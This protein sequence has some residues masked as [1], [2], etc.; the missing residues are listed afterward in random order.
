[1]FNSRLQGNR[2][3]RRLIRTLAVLSFSCVITGHAQAQNSRSFPAPP[4][5][6]VDIGTHRLHILCKGEGQPAIIIDAGLGSAALEWSHLQTILSERSKTCIYDRAG[7]GWSEAGPLPRTSNRIASELKTLL[8]E[9]GI[10]APY[11]L[12]G[13]SF[14]GYNMQI[15]AS[16]N[17]YDVAGLLLVDSSHPEQVQR[18][19]ADPINLKTAPRHRTGIVRYSLPRLPENLPVGLEDLTFKLLVQMKA[20]KALGD[21]MLEFR[22]SA[23]Q[24]QKAGALPDVPMIVLSRGIRVY[25]HDRRGDLMEALWVDL[26]KELAARSLHSAHVIASASKH[27]IHLDQPQLVDHALAYMLNT[28]EQQHLALAPW[29]SRRPHTVRTA[30]LQFG[31]AV[32]VSNHLRDTPSASNSRHSETL[33]TLINGAVIDQLTEWAP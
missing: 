7:Y 11:V 31:D 22:T 3:C 13:H 1:M 33:L 21:E 32:V 27:H 16:R 9:A 17:P 15:F 29:S 19:E 26:Q 28:L 25:P 5:Q 2:L 6:M 18:F 24:V 20:R 10:P 12:V 23:A 30:S 14:G 8:T 4:G